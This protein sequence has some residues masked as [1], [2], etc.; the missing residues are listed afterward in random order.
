LTDRRRWRS[1]LIPF[2]LVLLFYLSLAVATIQDDSDSLDYLHTLQEDL[3]KARAAAQ[4]PVA[5]GGDLLTLS[6]ACLDAGDDLYSD[7]ARRRQA[8]EEGAEAALRAIAL[9][10]ETA[11]AH[12]L[13]AANLGNAVQLGGRARAAMSLSTIKAHL[14]RAIALNP[15]HA[16]ALQF[17][18]GLLADLPWFLGG[19]MDEAERYLHRAIQADSR[20][21]NAR[22]LLAK[23]YLK[24]GRVR[25]AREQLNG[26]LTVVNPHYPYHWRRK[27]RPE[28]ERLLQSLEQ[29]SR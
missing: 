11:E 1:F 28:A 8:Y 17:M 2:P 29:R 23:L 19:R 25:E 5:T 27:F 16:R 24:Q 12:F 14:A 20:Y 13:Y 4:S 26:V 7:P 18:G 22:L 9:S 10:E 15:H 3:L 6:Q 21:T